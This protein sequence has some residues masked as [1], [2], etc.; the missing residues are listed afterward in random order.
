MMKL[1]FKKPIDPKAKLKC[2]VCKKIFK[3]G[4]EAG[5][6]WKETGHNSWVLL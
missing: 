1:P 2:Q 4:Y 3:N 5:E 6:H